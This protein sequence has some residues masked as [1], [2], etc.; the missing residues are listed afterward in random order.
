MKSILIKG[1]TREERDQIVRQSLWGDCGIECEFCSGC[2]NR[3]GSYYGYSL[4]HKHLRIRFVK[5]V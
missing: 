4:I 5:S 2:D 3:G 1:T